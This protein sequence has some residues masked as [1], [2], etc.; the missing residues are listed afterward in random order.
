[1][2]ATCVPCSQSLGRAGAGHAGAGRRR[3]A[4]AAGA[5]AG[6]RSTP[7]TRLC[8]RGSCAPCRRRCRARRRAG[9]RRRGRASWPRSTRRAACSG[10][11]SARPARPAGC[12]RPGRSA[13]AR[14]SAS[15]VQL[16]RDRRD[17]LERVDDLVLRAVERA[18]E[19]LARAVD[20]GA[21][22]LDA[23]V[24]ELA[25]GRELASAGRRSR[26]P[27]PCP[28]P[29][30]RTRRS[31]LAWPSGRRSGTGPA[32]PGSAAARP[33]RVR[34]PGRP[35][36]EGKGEDGDRPGDARREPWRHMTL[37]ESE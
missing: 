1:M 26:A 18:D 19:P 13:R 35:P 29:A 33:R 36:G 37:L 23:L 20:L 6:R 15:G 27:C 11:A 12:W 8:R 3:V 16:E 28:A 2:P 21:L 34:R 22:L 30:S 24:V 10:R 31:A 17:R 5:V 4:R 7:P 32:G 14:P 9:R 25:L